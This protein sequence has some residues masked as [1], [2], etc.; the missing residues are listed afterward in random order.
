MM[1]LLR[2]P[3]TQV[4]APVTAD[5]NSTILPYKQFY[6]ASFRAGAFDDLRASNLKFQFYNDC[7]GSE[8]AILGKDAR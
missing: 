5:R 4:K 2:I 7:D 3:L 1:V 6:W 8:S